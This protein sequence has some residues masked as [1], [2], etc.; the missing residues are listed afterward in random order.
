MGTERQCRGHE[1][2]RR[3]RRWWTRGG[4]RRRIA[5]TGPRILMSK[6][7]AGEGAHPAIRSDVWP[8]SC[9]D[10]GKNILAWLKTF[11]TVVC[12]CNRTASKSPMTSRCC[13]HPTSQ[14]EAVVTRWFGA[15]EGTWA[16]N[17]LA[18][19]PS[20]MDTM[21][22]VTQRCLLM[23]SNTCLLPLWR[24]GANNAS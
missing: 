8:Q 5:S 18:P 6:H 17:S 24:T 10:R 12:G 4:L 15:W 16:L 13:L 14:P 20:P 1:C 9:L 3:Y 22:A 21:P 11:P 19:R 2:A 7:A 23:R